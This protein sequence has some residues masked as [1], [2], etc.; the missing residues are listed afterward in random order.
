MEVKGGGA[1][2]PFPGTVSNPNANQVTAVDFDVAGEDWSWGAYRVQSLEAQGNVSAVEGLRLRRL[3][4]NSDGAV[5]KIDGNLFGD[6]QNAAFAVIDLPAQRLAPIIHH[7]ASA[8]SASAGRRRRRRRRF[9]PSRARSSSPATSGDPSRVPR[10]A[11]A[12]TSGTDAWV[13]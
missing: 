4:L 3:E 10:G 1:A 7:I 6:A 9:P 11:F 12:R 8:A 2:T 5:V 13:R